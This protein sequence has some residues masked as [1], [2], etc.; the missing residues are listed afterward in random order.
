MC[1]TT[2]GSKRVAVIGAG[3]GGLVAAKLLRDDGFAVRVF[4]SADQ[5]GGIWVYDKASP[6]YKSLRTN[7][8]KEIM[9]Y[10]DFPFDAGLPSFVKHT[11]VLAYLRS[12]ADHFALHDMISL[13][14]PVE[15][16]EYVSGESGQGWR[17]NGEEALYPSLFVSNGHYNTP[18]YPRLVKNEFRG[19]VTHSKFYKEPSPYADQRV[20]VVGGGPSG[21][22]LAWELHSVA[23]SVVWADSSF[24][25]PETAEATKS[26]LPSNVELVGRVE[27]LEED[28]RYLVIG[29]DGSTVTSDD[30]VDAVIWATGYKY[31]FPF[32]SPS[33]GLIP[34]TDGSPQP[35]FDSLYVHLFHKAHSASLFFLGLPVRIIP[36]PMMESQTKAAIAVMKGRV[37]TEDLASLPVFPWVMS[38]EQFP[39]CAL[40]EQLAKGTHHS[41]PRSTDPAND[42]TYDTMKLPRDIE[43]RRQMYADSSLAKR[44]V[45]GRYRERNYRVLGA[46]GEGEI[47]WEVTEVPEPVAA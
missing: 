44:R 13:S 18:R 4:E 25:D 46:K 6:L 29:P 26:K 19:L 37:K 39:Y 8:P 15:T 5:L 41:F 1:T 33:S 24:A 10:S 7:I 32:F 30:R 38:N 2:A 14:T 9:A 28:G 45:P 35:L 11:D 23:K 40:L 3:A 22:D 34:S 21:V 42:P 16:A 12:Y 47:E 17:I 27:G 36:F 20:L 43:L 31:D